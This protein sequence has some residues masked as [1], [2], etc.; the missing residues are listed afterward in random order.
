MAA[1]PAERARATCSCDRR[2]AVRTSLVVKRVLVSS[3]NAAIVAIMAAWTM[4]ELASTWR[5]VKSE[6]PQS[7]SDWVGVAVVGVFVSWPFG[8]IALIFLLHR[9]KRT[10]VLHPSSTLDP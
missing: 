2:R 5:W 4:E 6:P 9:G 7:L 10:K 8:L 3:F 1:A